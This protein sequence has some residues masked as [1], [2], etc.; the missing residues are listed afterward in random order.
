MCSTAGVLLSWPCSHGGV[1]V[2]V[3]GAPGIC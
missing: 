1:E 3:E 2:T